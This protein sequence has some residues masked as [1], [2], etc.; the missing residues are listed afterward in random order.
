MIFVIINISINAI[1]MWHYC[2]MIIYCVACGFRSLK[3]WI[4]PYTEINGIWNGFPNV[5][6][7]VKFELTQHYLKIQSL[8]FSSSNL[9][10]ETEIHPLRLQELCWDS[11]YTCQWCMCVWMAASNTC[12]LYDFLT[13]CV[14]KDPC[15]SLSLAACFSLCV[16]LKVRKATVSSSALGYFDRQMDSLWETD[17]PFSQWE[18][19]TPA[20]G[21]VTVA[22]SDCIRTYSWWFGGS[23]HVSLEV[24]GGEGSAG[25]DPLNVSIRL[26]L[27]LCFRVHMAQ[28]CPSDPWQPH[29]EG[30]QEFIPKLL[31]YI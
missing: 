14:I 5:F 26:R 28:R 8:Y 18:N 17:F 13:L 6:M 22:M 11:S 23:T 25:I 4:Q 21:M 7:Y 9:L 1:F 12:C 30:L 3:R 31:V 19:R 27:P 16:C 15:F 20:V 10:G 2:F 24:K 29:A